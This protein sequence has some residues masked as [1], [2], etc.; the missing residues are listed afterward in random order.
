MK[1][2]TQP[3]KAALLNERL[4]ITMDIIEMAREMG[5]VLQEDPRYKQ[6]AAAK[7]AND[8]DLDLQKEIADFNA[9]K[10][11]LNIE[12]AKTDKDTEAITAINNKLNALFASVTQNPNM[13]AFEAARDQLDEALESI[14]YILTCA[15]NGDDP[16]TCP[17]KP[18]VSCGGSCASCAGCH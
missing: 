6:F 1:K 9:A 3:L 2:Y 8:K 4:V 14:H 16:M 18:P 10:M 13:V 15:A 11:E 5:K 7:L 12:M 17:E